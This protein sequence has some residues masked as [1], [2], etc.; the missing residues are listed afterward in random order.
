MLEDS[1]E[2]DDE[3]EEELEEKELCEDWEDLDI[4]ELFE[5]WLD[6]LDDSLDGKTWVETEDEEDLSLL[7]DGLEID[8]EEGD[9]EESE[10]C[11]DNEDFED[12]DGELEELEVLEAEDTEET[13]DDVED[14][15]D[16]ED[17][18]DKLDEELFSESSISANRLAVSPGL[19]MNG[20]S[21]IIYFDFDPESCAKTV[22]I[23]PRVMAIEYCL[24]MPFLLN[25]IPMLWTITG[26]LLENITDNGLDAPDSKSISS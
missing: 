8:E 6:W 16:W 10:D 24:G 18:E 3:F 15:D 9:D 21:V 13:E 12:E 11:E 4:D 20:P 7:D 2:A 25:L 1:V 17:E 22:V 14:G 19:R 5:D 26:L 23:P